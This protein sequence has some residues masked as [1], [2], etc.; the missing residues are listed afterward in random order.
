MEVS[1]RS[2]NHNRQDNK[3]PK[4]T[5]NLG[6]RPAIDDLQSKPNAELLN[7]LGESVQEIKIGFMR[8]LQKFGNKSV[9]RF[10]QR[11][12]RKFDKKY[13]IP[14]NFAYLKAPVLN[15]VLK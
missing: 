11:I 10:F 5:E 1:K 8:K 3:V 12:K 9:K 4:T 6:E 14:E 13:L 7:L 2:K 15:S